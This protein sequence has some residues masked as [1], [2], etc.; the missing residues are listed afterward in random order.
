PV[1]LQATL[2]LLGA[3]LAAWLTSREG[4][5]PM[6]LTRGVAVAGILVAV[7]ALGLFLGPGLTAT[8]ALAL[9][10]AGLAGALP[11]A[12]P[13]RLLVAAGL[14]LAAG[15]LALV[16]WRRVLLARTGLVRP[17]ILLI[18]VVAFASAGSALAGG[19]APGLGL[20]AVAT[21]RAR[22]GE[23]PGYLVPGAA[24][25]A[26]AVTATLDGAAQ[27]IAWP[28]ELP[29]GVLTLLLASLLLGREVMRA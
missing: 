18:G 27:A 26:V 16:G 19:V 13:E 25:A 8:T 1:L 22:V 3:A 29:V 4:G 14:V 23:H 11:S 2:A 10:H 12:T 5:L 7:A 17:G 9:L 24:L 6:V 15:T 21:V 20:L 28:G